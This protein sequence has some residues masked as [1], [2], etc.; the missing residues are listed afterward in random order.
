MLNSGRWIARKSA[1]SS[2]V[3]EVDPGVAV[4]AVVLG[5]ANATEEQLA[6]A[7]VLERGEKLQ[8]AT[9]AAEQDFAQV[10]EAVDGLF[11]GCEFAGGVAVA[12]FHLAVVL[13]EGNVVAGGFEA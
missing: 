6:D 1:W 9:V 5:L 3:E 12:M 10:D 7:V 2:G 11:Q 13:E 8:V 4:L